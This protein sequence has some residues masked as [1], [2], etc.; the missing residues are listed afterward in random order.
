VSVRRRLR[1]AWSWV[2]ADGL[3]LTICKLLGHR[4]QTEDVVRFSRLLGQIFPKGPDGEIV[5]VRCG[6]LL[7]AGFG[8]FASRSS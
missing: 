5:C 6:G 1:Y 3:G 7:F 2:R 8:P 4:P